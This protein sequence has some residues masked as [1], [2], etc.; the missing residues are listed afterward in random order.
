MESFTFPLPNGGTIAGIHNIPPRSKSSVEHRPLVVGLHGGMYECHYFD[1]DSKHTASIWSNA[2]GVPF[3][4]IDRPCYGGTSSFLPVPEGSDFITESANW[5]HKYILPTLWSRIGIPN[6]CNC[7]VLFCHSLGAMYGVATAALHSQE[8]RQSYPL[9][10]LICSGIG[11]VWEPHMYEAAVGEPYDAMGKNGIPL[12][13]KDKVMFRPGT[14]HPDILK[15]SERLDSPAPL[16]ELASL[17][18]TWLPNWKNQWAEHV[19]APVMFAMVEQEPFFVVSGER[20][21]ACAEAFSSSPR[22][23]SSFVSGAPHCMELSYWAQGWYARSFGFAMEC[24]AHTGLL[25]AR[26]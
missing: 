3:V 10:G 4:S 21:K 8:G 26:K 1:A 22:V 12:E 6:G 17:P 15:H 18:A 16:A 13:A 5:L 23:D 7:V 20:L 2:Y 19:K 25:S 24:S 14:V 11:D 9:G